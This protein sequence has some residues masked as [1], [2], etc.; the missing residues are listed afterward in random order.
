MG[1][2]HPLFTRRIVVMRLSLRVA[3]LVAA[4]L[5]LGLF[6]FGHGRGSGQTVVQQFFSAHPHSVAFG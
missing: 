1:R 3:A 2:G 6:W 4:F 5:V